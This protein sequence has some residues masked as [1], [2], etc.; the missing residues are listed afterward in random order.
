M[1]VSA[2]VA[3]IVADPGVISSPGSRTTRAVWLDSRAKISAVRH[4]L[5]KAAVL[6][7]ARADDVAGWQPDE[8]RQWRV[9]DGRLTTLS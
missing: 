4:A 7:T 2:L 8:V 3:E 5:W 6:S 9:E 1:P